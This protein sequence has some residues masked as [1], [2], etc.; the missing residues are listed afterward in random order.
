MS[1]NATVS[2]LTVIDLKTASKLLGITPFLMR[3]ITK[4]R[5]VPF[6]QFGKQYFYRR[7]ALADFLHEQEETNMQKPA[8]D[9]IVTR[10]PGIRRVDEK[11]C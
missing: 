6:L 8:T 9:T 5:R 3:K 1:Q 4:E 2:D 11:E 7:A 10:E